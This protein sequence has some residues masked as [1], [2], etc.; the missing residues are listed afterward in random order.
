MPFTAAGGNLKSTFITEYEIID[1][2]VG[3]QLWGWGNDG[4]GRLGDNATV[5]KSSPVQTVSAGT[6]WRNVN[7]GY[8]FAAGLKTD[9]TLWMWGANTTG[10]LGNNN[11][12]AQ[13]SPVQTV[14]SINC[15]KQVSTGRE[16]TIALRTNGTVWLWGTNTA[17]QLG[18]NTVANQ[19]SPVQ[20]V[21]AGTNWK[22][23]SAGCGHSGAIKTDGTLWLWGSNAFGQLGNNTIAS[24]SSPIQTISAGTDWK[25]VS[26]SSTRVAAIKT[27]GSLWLWGGNSTGELGN[28]AIIP[29]SSPVQTV[30]A[31][32]NW[33]MVS[34]GVLHT[35]AIK[36]DGSLWL[37]GQGAAGKLGNN[38][39][40]NQSSPVQTV[41]GGTNWKQVG[42]NDSGA[43]G[44]AIKTDGTLWVWGLN[45][46][47]Q[48]GTNN[49]TSQ[50][51]PVQTISSGTSWKQVSSAAA[52]MAAVTFTEL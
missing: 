6:N 26:V 34:N 32:T 29:R 40:A 1:R 46:T 50:S 17:G 47:G 31:G 10:Q 15:W 49:V 51:S 37:W 27:D 2:Y 42:I 11:V 21:S 48:L 39:T 12:T 36:T 43:I 7:M 9:G 22:Q 23:V 44:A 35:A 30:S 5:N 28:N 19:S 18:T 24:Q 16:Q 52:Q 13:S 33:V 45:A 25:N 20:T 14:A 4:S 3:N 38:S 8:T 41:S